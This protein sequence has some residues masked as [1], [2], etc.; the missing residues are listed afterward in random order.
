MI[1]NVINTSM[2]RKWW[3]YLIL[4]VAIELVFVLIFSVNKIFPFAIVSVIFLAFL[5]FYSLTVKPYLW[6]LIMIVGSFLDNWGQIGGG[7]TVFHVGWAGAILSWFVYYHYNHS[8]KAIMQLP[9]SI[10]FFLY[11]GLASVSLIYTPN[12]SSAI[13]FIS[14]TIALYFFAIWLINFLKTE[15]EFKVIVFILL[16]C[17]IL[18]AGLI[19][20]QILTFDPWKIVDVALSETGEKILRPSGTFIDPNVAAAHIVVGLLYGISLL[21]YAKSKASLKYLLSFA[22]LISIFGIVLT[23]SRT[24][25][26]SLLAGI[27]SLL[28]FQSKKNNLLIL[29]I[30]TFFIS[31]IIFFTPYGT[32]ITERVSSI[33]D[34]MGDVSIRTRLSLIISGFNMFIDH[35]LLGIGYRGFPIYYDYYIDPLAP[36][37]LLYVKESHTLLITLLAEMSIWGVIIVFLWF[38]RVIL[39]INLLL[40]FNLTPIKKA[41]LIGSLANIIS[42]I[43]YSFFYGNIFPHFNF[44]WLIFGMVYSIYFLNQDKTQ[45]IN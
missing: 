13:S 5:F 20:Y 36:Q 8:P 17:N 44:L 37:V 27:L 18:L 24:V 32:F 34:L 22:I 21:F 16:L 29:F 45:T 2:Q 35:P 9:I 43:V 15:N 10:Y 1:A 40:K 26:I 4:L 39:D 25:W 7:L 38:K 30:F 6:L 19:F 11:I 31:V 33:F 23:F 3:Q 12:F 14:T 42:F 28:F 41:V